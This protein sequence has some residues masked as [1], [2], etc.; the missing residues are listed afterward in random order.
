MSNDKVLIELTRRQELAA[1]AI[2]APWVTVPD[3]LSE[4][5]TVRSNHRT[6]AVIQHDTGCGE[7]IADSGN[8]RASELKALETAYLYLCHG[9]NDLARH[10]IR[11]AILKLKDGKEG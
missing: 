2:S 9:F 6:V 4:G 3:S 7:F 8:N 1:R 5:A 10:A 11:D